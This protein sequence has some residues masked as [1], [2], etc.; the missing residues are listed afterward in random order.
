MYEETSKVNFKIFGLLLIKFLNLTNSTNT[1]I[2][3]IE[4][5][6]APARTWNFSQYRKWMG[7]RE[8]HWLF[9]F[10]EKGKCVERRAKDREKWR[11]NWTSDLLGNHFT[12][13][14]QLNEFCIYI[15]SFVFLNSMHLYTTRICCCCC[16]FLSWLDSVFVVFLRA[17][18]QFYRW[19]AFASSSLNKCAFD[20]LTTYYS[21]ASIGTQ[22]IIKNRSIK[23]TP[24]KFTNC[25]CTRV[26]CVVWMLYVYVR[27]NEWQKWSTKRIYR[28]LFI[29]FFFI[30]RRRKKQ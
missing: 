26:M 21:V 11:G 22:H 15:F 9:R 6:Q 27:L 25:Y 8:M 29:T 13:I 30:F 20:S 3:K 7:S 10:G 17:S 12:H 24:S 16:C 2:V 19:F 23:G 18:E 28:Y 14:A 4:Y 5:L 1:W